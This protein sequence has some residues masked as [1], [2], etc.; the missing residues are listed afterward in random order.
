VV[1]GAK[2]ID[3]GAVQDAESGA[4]LAYPLASSAPRAR[5]TFPIM[6]LPRS[7]N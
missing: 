6:F 2:W 3:G 1:S 7:W 4:H 5:V